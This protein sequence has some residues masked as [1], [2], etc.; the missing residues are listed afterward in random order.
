MFHSSLLYFNPSCRG[1]SSRAKGCSRASFAPHLL[2][3]FSL[4]VHDGSSGLIDYT[5]GL[6]HHYSHLFIYSHG[7]HSFNLSFSLVAPRFSPPLAHSASSFGPQADQ[8]GSRRRA[9]ALPGLC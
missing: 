7:A 3:S 2:P 5:T 8:A 4:L 1:C 9:R 6:L